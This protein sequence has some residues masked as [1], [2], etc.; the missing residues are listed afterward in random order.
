MLS[1]FDPESWKRLLIEIIGRPV[2]ADQGT[3]EQRMEEKQ[4]E[5]GLGQWDNWGEVERRVGSK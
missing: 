3:A 5:I 2:D 4:V 1:E